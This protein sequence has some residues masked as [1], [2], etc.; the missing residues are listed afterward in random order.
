MHTVRWDLAAGESDAE[1]GP[2]FLYYYRAR[3]YD[4][5]IGRFL[6]EDPIHFRGG[7]NFYLYVRNDPIQL[8]D[9]QGLTPCNNCESGC[10]LA[11]KGEGPDRE[12]QC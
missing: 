8:R 10:L 1:T 7:I 12:Q 2:I 9:R 4:P 11:K 5:T 3:Y 6:K